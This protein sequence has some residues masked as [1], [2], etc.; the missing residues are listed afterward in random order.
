MANLSETAIWESGIYQ[1]EVTDPVQGG[2]S[3]IANQQAKQL[4]NRTTFLKQQTDSLIANAGKRLFNSIE[5]IAFEGPGSDTLAF[6]TGRFGK[7]VNITY[8]GATGCTIN[9][10]LFSGM[11]SIANGERFVIQNN[12]SLTGDDY[13]ATI[14]TTDGIAN[15]DAMSATPIT[16]IILRAGEFVELMKGSDYAGNDRWILLDRYFKHERN[17]PAQVVA[18]ARNTPPT[19]WL[20]CNGGAVS[21]TTYA[22]LFA[23]I[24][25][26]FGVG[27]GS[28][29]FNLPDL[30]GEFVR[31]WDNGRGVDNNS[32]SLSASITN[33]SAN[34]TV[35]DTT[36]IAVGMLVTGTGIPALTTV[37]S[38]TSSTVFVLSNN[39][40]V[41]NGAAALTLTL[42]VFG[43]YQADAF[44]SH[45]HIMKKYNRSVGA[46]AGFFA[47][48]DSGTDGS[49]NTELTGGAETRPRNIALLYC[50][51]F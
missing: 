20:P 50:I 43:S 9:L 42:R 29:T 39:A 4:A 23:S 5:T 31:G 21:R 28:T 8:D 37:L 38:I 6:G 11:G 13:A 45:F 35:A 33:G 30:R 41:T 25:T 46:G 36:G 7:F 49:E 18:F 22:S 1:L 44:K 12:P 19:G 26:T 3:G 48:D 15:R 27:D 24:G 51:K 2:A 10:P 47:M 40:T 32:V 17:Q 16:S 34:V 14:N